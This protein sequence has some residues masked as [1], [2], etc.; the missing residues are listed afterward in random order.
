MTI[1][2]LETYILVPRDPADISLL[3]EAL[4]PTPS[5]WDLDVVIGMKG[6]IAPP[7]YV[8]RPDGAHRGLRPDLLTSLAR[9]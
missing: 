7:A 5:P 3:A 8:Q 9:R 2:G 4:R 6:P 1:E